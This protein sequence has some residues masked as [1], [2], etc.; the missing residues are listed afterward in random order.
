MISNVIE[1]IAGNRTFLITTHENPDGDAVGSSLA[2]ANYL[3]RQGKE[4]TGRVKR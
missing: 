3:K 4:V 1:E 2:L